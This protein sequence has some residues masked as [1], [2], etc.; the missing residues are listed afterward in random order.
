MALAQLIFFKE[1]SLRYHLTENLIRDTFSPKF[2]YC[3]KNWWVATQVKSVFD[4]MQIL[5]PLHTHLQ[6]DHFFQI[7]GL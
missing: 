6:N 1:I 2:V 7:S 4:I 3:M 5:R